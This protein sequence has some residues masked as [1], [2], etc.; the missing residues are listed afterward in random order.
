MS[1]ALAHR[2]QTTDRPVQFVGLVCEHPPVDARPPVRSEHQGDLVEREAGAA[3]QRD[4]CQPLQHPGIE[5]AAQP[6]P[7]D[8]GD[9]PF[10]FPALIDLT[11][12]G[13]RYPGALRMVGGA[14][15]L[16]L[17]GPDSRSTYAHAGGV[18]RCP[19]ALHRDGLARVEQFLLHRRVRLSPRRSTSSR[20]PRSSMRPT[21]GRSSTH[22]A[23]AGL[24]PS[25]SVSTWW[26]KSAW[27]SRVWQ[28]LLWNP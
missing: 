11:H 7:A 17:D 16:D 3:A 26:C 2:A 22:H 24:R 19:G 27:R 13:G 21:A 9:Q 15:A 10:F 20:R 12:T 25:F 28:R 23:R 5:Q 8:R 18:A 4:Q 14:R 1:Q 6:P